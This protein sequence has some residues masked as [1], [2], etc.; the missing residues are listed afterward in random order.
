MPWKLGKRKPA[1]RLQ[2]GSSHWVSYTVLQ[3]DKLVTK[4]VET[5][6]TKNIVASLN[7]TFGEG[8]GAEAEVTR[9]KSVITKQEGASHFLVTN[10]RVRPSG[11]PGNAAY[12]VVG[13]TVPFPDGCKQLRVVACFQGAQGRWVPYKNKVYTKEAKT[14]HVTTAVNWQLDGYRS[15]QGHNEN[16]FGTMADQHGLDGSYCVSSQSVR[17]EYCEPVREEF[18]QRL[19][20]DIPVLGRYADDSHGDGGLLSYTNEDELWGGAVF[21]LPPGD[22]YTGGDG[23]WG[24]PACL[25]DLFR[26]GK[27]CCHPQR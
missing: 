20:T 11:M 1:L 26:K 21:T 18:S 7:A 16:T 12:D 23:G 15:G 8:A 22:E 27:S 17:E 4:T 3:E 14:V 6:A 5:D 2:N 13:T 19:T 10:C 24:F 9:S 25:K